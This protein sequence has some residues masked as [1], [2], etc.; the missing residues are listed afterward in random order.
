MLQKKG[1]FIN[2]VEIGGMCNMYY[3]LRGEDAPGYGNELVWPEMKI[4][5]SDISDLLSPTLHTKL[6]K[7]HKMS[8]LWHRDIC[9]DSVFCRIRMHDVMK[10]NFIS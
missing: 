10:N 2:F 1:E 4:T 6:Y 9:K 5:L 3:W 7:H 8:P